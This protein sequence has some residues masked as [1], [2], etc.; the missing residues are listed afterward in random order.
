MVLENNTHVITGV[1]QMGPFDPVII[2]AD[3][4]LPYMENIVDMTQGLP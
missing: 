1:K 3:L 4:T 2:E